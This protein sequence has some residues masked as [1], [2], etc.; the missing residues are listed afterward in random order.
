MLIIRSLKHLKKDVMPHRKYCDIK[1]SVHCFNL[2]FPYL[3]I[4]YNPNEKQISRFYQ[5]LNS[6]I[7]PWLVWLSGLST[8]L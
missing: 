5:C 3:S 6:G 7:E 1:I 2:L 8:S 4:A